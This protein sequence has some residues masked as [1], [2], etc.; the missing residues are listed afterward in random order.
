MTKYQRKSYYEDDDVRVYLEKIDEQIF[1]HVAIFNM[2]K[3]VL[4]KIKAVWGEVVIKMYYDGY[5][6][7]FAYTKDNRII[8]L[9]GGAKKIGEHQ[10]YEVYQWDLK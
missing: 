5:E 2:T 9:I 6:D 10:E 4:K 7:L 3:K 8:K 1:I